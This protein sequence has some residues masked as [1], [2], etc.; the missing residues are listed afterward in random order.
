MLAHCVLKKKRK[1][2]GVER[3]IPK[4][5]NPGFVLPSK[6]ES[7]NGFVF[8]ILIELE[9]VRVSTGIRILS[10]KIAPQ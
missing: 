10:V 1:S 5:H 6:T 2:S 7:K 3:F 8:W 9:I 4:N